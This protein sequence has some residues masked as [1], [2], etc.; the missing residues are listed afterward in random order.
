MKNNREVEMVLQ[1]AKLVD[2]I[3]KALSGLEHSFPG[4]INFKNDSCLNQTGWNSKY[5]I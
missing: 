3:V 5:K 2:Q 4:S 1:F